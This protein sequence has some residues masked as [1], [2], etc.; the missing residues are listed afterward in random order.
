MENPNISKSVTACILLA[1]EELEMVTELA[2]IG[3]DIVKIARVLQKDVRLV[4]R[5]WKTVGTPIYEAYHS[6]T[7][8]AKAVI[9]KVVYE[10]ASKGNLTAIQ[11]YAK[12]Q[13]EQKLDNM[14]EEIFN[15]D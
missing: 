1:Y 4:K 15:T 3:F 11:Q 10:N 7:L 13:E 2:A 6:G 12:L 14:K 8:Q 9:D 5:D